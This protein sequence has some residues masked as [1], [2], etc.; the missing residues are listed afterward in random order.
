MKPSDTRTGRS[1]AASPLP[2]PVA[3]DPD[4]DSAKGSHRGGRSLVLARIV[5]I[6]VALASLCLF[7]AGVPS[8]FAMY[9]TVCQ[10]VCVGGQVSPAGSQALRDLGLSLDFYAAYA[11]ALDIVFATLYAAVAVIIFWR[12]SGERVALL[13]AFALFTFGTAGLPNAMYALSVQHASLW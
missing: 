3:T 9:H 10:H 2:S 13:A 11:V 7:A 12:K 4:H 5:W 1:N 8:E 6:V